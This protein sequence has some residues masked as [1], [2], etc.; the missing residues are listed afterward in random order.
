MDTANVTFNEKTYRVPVGTCVT[1]ILGHAYIEEHSVIGAL[2]NNHLVALSTTLHGDE[3]LEAVT[4]ND[5]EGQAILRRSASLML[6]TITARKYPEWVFSI[7]QSLLGGYFYEIEAPEG[8]EIDLEELAKELTEELCNI[9][10]S[11]VPF[12]EMRV[13]VETAHKLLTDVHNHKNLLLRTWPSA[14]VPMV[15]INGFADI[16]HG[17]YAPSTRYIKDVKLVAY[18][19]GL[20]L[21]FSPEKVRGVP[22]EGRRL[23]AGY[24]E[25]RD[26]NRRV[27]VATVGDLNQAILDDRIHDVMRVAEGLHEKKI[28]RIADEI[29]ER[30]NKV[31]IVCVAGPSSSGKTTFVK[32]LSVQLRVNGLNPVLIG[33]DDYYRDRT[34]TPIDKNGE[35]DFEAVEALNVPLLHEHLEAL[36]QG[37]EVHI[38]RFDFPSGSPVPES[39]WRPLQLGKNQVLIIEGI[40][41]LNPWL[42][43]PLSDDLKYRVFIN[44]LTQLVIDEHNR[45]FTSDARLLRRLVRD[46]RYR[47]TSAAD[48]IERWPSVRRGEEKHIFPFQEESDV[49]FNSALVYETAMLKI[50]AWRY[51]LEVPREHP[52]RVRAYQ[53]LKFLELFVPIFPDD[54]PANS[55]LREFIGGSG[56]DY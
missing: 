53:L 27:G 13:P 30:R 17:P 43:K 12:K 48:T 54:V 56:F 15:R 44:A 51:L 33:L 25:T 39:E 47:G 50:F 18:E 21:Q 20:V 28:A 38:P 37:K 16:R 26:W 34:E 8:V 5:H 35:Y 2:L 29:S 19:P 6:H 42:T 1:E 40:H 14:T 24:S 31:R 11:D 46:R 9:A 7:G 3:S 55:L 41:A 36:I 10:K 22:N 4:A 32:R 45:I 52:S 23:Y 49:M